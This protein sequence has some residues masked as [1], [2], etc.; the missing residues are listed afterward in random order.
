MKN[1]RPV[2]ALKKREWYSDKEKQDIAGPPEKS[3]TTKVL[4]G[5]W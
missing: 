1:S 5:T 3:S 2:S 4:Q